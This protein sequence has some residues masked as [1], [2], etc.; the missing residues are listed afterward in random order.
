MNLRILYLITR[1]EHG[2]AQVHVLE[3]L[4]GISHR[5][6]VHLGVGEEGFLTEEARWLGVKVHL[7]PN[8]VQPLNPSKDLKALWEIRRLIRS[9]RPRLV[10]LHSSKAGLLGRLAAVLVGTPAIFTAHGW[11]FTDGVSWKR[12][13]LAVPSEWLAAR[14]GGR[15]I[16]VSQNDYD[17]ALRYRVASRQQM[18]VVHNGIPDVPYRARP[19]AEPVRIVMVARFTPPKDHVLLLR[20]LAGLKE[21]AWELEL[22]GDGPLLGRVRAEAERLG[23]L[24]RVRFLGARRDVAERLSKAQVFVLASNWEGLPLSIL[25]AMRAG[26]PVVASDVGGVREAVIEGETAFLV[27]RGDKAALRSRLQQLITN[28]SLRVEMGQAGRKRFEERF[29]FEFMLEKT[30]EVYE[31]VLGTKLARNGARKL[32]A[33]LR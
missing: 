33:S 26:L 1:A 19:E 6:E 11:A 30:L 5:F 13:A 18:T 14:L 22:I 27:P 21:L 32:S 25:E 12:K 24:K 28:A 16:T 31:T 17:L 8:L 10:H 15:I 7:I 3:L 23:L 9:L 20:A 29:T 4:R 2:G